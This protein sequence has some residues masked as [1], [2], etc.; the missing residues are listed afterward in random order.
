[1]EAVPVGVPSE[2]SLEHDYSDRC[3]IRTR[4]LH[5][6]R[7]RCA[8]RSK[9]WCTRTPPRYRALVDD[10]APEALAAL[11]DVDGLVRFLDN[12]DRES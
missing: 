3:A 4:N 5:L 10:D 11:Q 6:T 8:N 12:R 7:Y 1:M 9:A 2:A